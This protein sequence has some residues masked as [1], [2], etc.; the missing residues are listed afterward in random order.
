MK[1]IQTILIAASILTVGLGAC[2]KD[3]NPLQE[4]KTLKDKTFELQ[5]ASIT[6]N[7]WDGPRDEYNGFH[8]GQKIGTLSLKLTD[9]ESEF[10]YAYKVTLST[11]TKPL[12]END[13]YWL[14]HAKYT[15][16]S[17]KYRTWFDNGPHYEGVYRKSEFDEEEMVNLK[18]DDISSMSK[19]DDVFINEHASYPVR[20][21]FK[22]IEQ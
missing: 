18:G 19:I 9:E 6:C 17:V 10:W 8:A 7:A 20:L 1:K 14:D 11:E 15:T 3:E 2:S 5:V 22:V 16:V 12:L 21:I 13:A 4:D